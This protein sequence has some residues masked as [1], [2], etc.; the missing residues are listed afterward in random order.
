MFRRFHLILKL[1]VSM[2]ALAAT[3]CFAYQNDAVP[4]VGFGKQAGAH[5]AI[6][7]LALQQFINTIAPKDKVFRRYDFTP[8]A[9]QYKLDKDLLAFWVEAD[10]VIERGD[11]YPDQ[12][13][14]YV[15]AWA[16]YSS[17]TYKE[18]KTNQPFSW[19]V[20]E[21]GFSADEPE[22]WQALRHFYDPCS[23]SRDDYDGGKLVSYL[24]D[25]MNRTLA[26]FMSGFAPKV[27]AK[28]LALTGSP[29]SWK[30]GRESLDKAFAVGVAIPGKRAYFGNAWRALGECMHLLA[31]MGLPAHVR[32]DAHPAQTP[33]RIEDVVNFKGDPFEM[34]A[35]AAQI[36]VYGHGS[37][38]PLATKIINAAN[39]PEQL[40]QK[41]AEYTNTNFFSID[42]ISGI[43]AVSKKDVHSF[44]GQPDYPSP[45]LDQYRFEPAPGDNGKKGTGW[46]I[47]ADGQQALY[48]YASGKYSICEVEQAKQLIPAVVSANAKL[49]GMFLPRV[50]VKI[51]SYDPKTRTL[52]C[53]VVEFDE[54]G[55]AGPS[56][57]YI[58]SQDN[59][60]LIVQNSM[61]PVAVK[62][63][64]VM[65]ASTSM[66]IPGLGGLTDKIKDIGKELGKAVDKAK[67]K[68]ESATKGTKPADKPASQPEKTKP[69]TASPKTPV[70]PAS[71]IQPIRGASYW[72]PVSDNSPAAFK[73]NLPSD[74]TMPDGTDQTVAAVSLMVGVDMGGI[75]VKSN[76]FVLAPIRIEPEPAQVETPK[77]LLSLQAS[78]SPNPVSVQ[79]E[80]GDNTP[81]MRIEESYDTSHSYEKDGRYTV[82]CLALDTGENETVAQGIGVVDIKKDDARIISPD[83]KPDVKPDIKPYKPDTSSTLEVALRDICLQVWDSTRPKDQNTRLW[84][85]PKYGFTYEEYKPSS[86]S[87]SYKSLLWAYTRVIERGELH[88]LE[89]KDGFYSSKTPGDYKPVAYPYVVIYRCF[90]SSAHQG[91]LEEPKDAKG[92]YPSVLRYA[93]KKANDLQMKPV[94]LGDKAYA[95]ETACLAVRGPICFA[96][97]V[98]L[99]IAFQ[100]GRSGKEEWSGSHPEIYEPKNMTK[101]NGWL[102]GEPFLAKVPR[103]FAGRSKMAQDVCSSQVAAWDV[104]CGPQI[105][106]GNGFRGAFL[107]DVTSFFPRPNEIAAGTTME[108]REGR[109]PWDPDY[110]PGPASSKG[111]IN[112]RYAVKNKDSR[113]DIALGITAFPWKLDSIPTEECKKKFTEWVAL[114]K[115]PERISIPGIDEAY[116]MV[117]RDVGQN[118]HKII[119]RKANVLVVIDGHEWDKKQQSP[120]LNI[121]KMAGLIAAKIQAV[122]SGK[123]RQ[124]P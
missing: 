52:S 111:I 29:Y 82:T 105:A 89:D 55:V 58:N 119:M 5:S 84:D 70:D 40:F 36:E 50:G 104:W 26:P 11:W 54:N 113:Q 118:Y 86:E 115:R 8:T 48:R 37:G 65:V 22:T 2:V 109:Y 32:N 114:L 28:D 66:Q 95:N 6:N 44:N 3:A 100:L 108:G 57:K 97:T 33:K 41:L 24:T 76:E 124:Q 91:N 122:S 9:Q 27:N 123:G 117:Y 116:Q 92:Q 101:E 102:D 60:L 30:A 107:A 35:D 80:F 106:D 62:R 110:N 23:L 1:S 38:D 75:L 15:P 7:R 98:D 25:D 120:I 59:V 46:Y 45:K 81:K 94:M 51:D 53:R 77:H 87:S 17:Y 88:R 34:F 73:V 96:N 90:N 47:D 4:P 14:P 18:G 42:T 61:A 31:D 93:E 74:L 83:T 12:K 39:T 103:W 69:P 13:V 85:K 43:D 121:S 16:V 56:A 20:Y 19:W 79:W 99:T 72:L 21:G 64:R 71:A 68:I 63:D 67:E 10:A 78:Q 112:D 49:I